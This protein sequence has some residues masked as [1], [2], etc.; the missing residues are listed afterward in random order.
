MNLV[1]KLLRILELLHGGGGTNFIKVRF[2]L[3]DIEKLSA[4]GNAN[5][6]E[7]AKQLDN[8]YKFVELAVQ[9]EFDKT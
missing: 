5:A 2:L 9:Q 8:I 6:L 1:S 7:F 4:E 3:E